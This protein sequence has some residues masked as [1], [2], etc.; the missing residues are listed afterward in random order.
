[1]PRVAIV[2]DHLLLAETLRAAL[3][4]SG[5][6]PSVVPAAPV[7]ELLGDLLTLQPELVLLD[8]DLDQFGDSTPLIAPLVEAEVRVLLVT[9]TSDRLR[10]A[11]ALEQGALA[12]HRK[13]ADF[14]SLLAKTRQALTA[15]GP[16]DA[17]ER[18][19]LLDE[20][21]RS[22]LAAERTMA[23]FRRLTAR[24]QD[25]LRALAGGRSVNEIARDWVVA[26]ATVRSHVRGVLAK[27]GVG[28]QL[29]AVAIAAQSGWLAG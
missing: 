10:I 27:L 24:E 6:S 19:L 7:H 12:V 1:M 15:H 22:R 23:P 17:E 2:E 28:S 11:C 18:V 14:D 8:L 4:E 29:A 3:G 20:L 21:V 25:T 5:I 16:L 26:E 13:S 9:G